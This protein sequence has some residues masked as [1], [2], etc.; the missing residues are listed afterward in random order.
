MF[1]LE[2]GGK[3]DYVHASVE[4]ISTGDFVIYN[5]GY[6]DNPVGYIGAVIDVKENSIS[7]AFNIG[8]TLKINK[9]SPRLF[10]V[11]EELDDDELENDEPITGYDDF[12]YYLTEEAKSDFDNVEDRYTN[13]DIPEDELGDREQIDETAEIIDEIDRK[14][15]RSERKTGEE[16]PEEESPEEDTTSEEP[17]EGYEIEKEGEISDRISSGDTVVVDLYYD[18][19]KVTPRNTTYKMGEVQSVDREGKATVEF[20][21][22][23]SDSIKITDR[24]QDQIFEVDTSEEVEDDLFLE[25]LADLVPSS[26]L[27]EVGIW[28]YVI[29]EEPEETETEETSEEDDSEGESEEDIK[30]KAKDSSG[31]NR[32]R[33]G[34]RVIY[35]LKKNDDLTSKEHNFFLGTVKGVDEEEETLSIKFDDEDEADDFE[36]FDGI[37]FKSDVKK[38]HPRE[39]KYSEVSEFISQQ[40]ADLVKDTPLEIGGEEKQ[41]FNKGD[42]VIVNVGKKED[43]KYFFGIIDEI[44]KTSK[45]KKVT[46]KLDNGKEVK[47]QMN[48]NLL[49]KSDYSKDEVEPD[50]IDPRVVDRYIS[51]EKGKKRTPSITEKEEQFVD[52]EDTGELELGKVENILL[53]RQEDR[54]EM[55]KVFNPYEAPKE[56][57]RTLKLLDLD[58]PK[59]FAKQLGT[60][61]TK[62]SLFYF[63]YIPEKPKGSKVYAGTESIDDRVKPVSGNYYVA[64]L[65][66][67]SLNGSQ[68]RVYEKVG[69]ESPYKYVSYKA[70]RKRLMG[71]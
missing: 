32:F 10:K 22:G 24:N 20:F 71:S 39:I 13:D 27:K 8:N 70:F 43:P 63:P 52:E 54:N 48:S 55:V 38:K 28:D 3:P 42:R 29:E 51:S 37:V 9:G 16:T 2:I 33:K 53:P 64:N 65:Y 30:P 56:W 50:Q 66:D 31:I 49:F 58:N 5:D 34:D 12:T 17:E 69:E 23:T 18:N 26:T 57:A 15:D 60:D 62:K 61:P 45:D 11:D 68:I 7:V 25:D 44:D 19:P 67:G 36:F 1:K 40:D 46:V 35:D 6:P 4:D 59:E 14:D 21:D 47:K 41:R